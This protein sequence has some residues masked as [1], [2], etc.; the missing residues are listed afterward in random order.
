MSRPSSPTALP[1]DGGCDRSVQDSDYPHVRDALIW[2]PQLHVI[3]ALVLVFYQPPSPLQLAHVLDIPWEDV[4]ES[5]APV[6]DLLEPPG[7]PT[8]YYSDI[9]LSDHLRAWL[10]N[11]NPATHVDPRRWH[12]VLAVWC[13]DRSNIKY[14]ARDI[15]YASDFWAQHVCSARPSQDLWDSLRR[16]PIPCR[17]SSHAMLPWVITWLE[18]VDVED[19]REL[20]SMYR[21]AYRQTAS[22]LASGL[23][24]KIMG[25]LMSMEL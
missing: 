7:L 10:A 5:L 1:A 8:H 19:T 23:R 21:S 22:A 18:S 9:V 11:D 2:D 20:I 3:L 14:D 16:S 13:L 6:A 25:G 12:A 24:V 17:L 15:F 4:H